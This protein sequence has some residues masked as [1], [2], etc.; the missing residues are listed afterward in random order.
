MIQEF[1]KM[2]G[3]IIKKLKKIPFLKVAFLTTHDPSKFWVR[4]AITVV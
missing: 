4:L 3:S 2:G 1:Y